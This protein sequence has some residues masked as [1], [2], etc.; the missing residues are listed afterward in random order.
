[1]AFKGSFIKETI[2]LKRRCHKKNL[3]SFYSLTK[4]KNPIFLGFSA[5][6]VE[7]IDRA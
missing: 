5:T 6:K 2:A 1:M 4:F 7:E 3:G